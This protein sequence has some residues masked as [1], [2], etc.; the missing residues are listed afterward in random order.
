MTLIQEIK[1]KAKIVLKTADRIY[2]IKTGDII[3]CESTQNYTTFYLCDGSK[4]LI[5]ET[6]KKFDLHFSKKK[7]FRVHQSHLVN[8]DYLNYYLKGE[9]GYMVM[10]DNSKIPVSYRNKKRLLKLF[11]L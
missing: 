9:G 5:S 4:V 6:I 11:G 10:K 8:L 1:T 7:I 3:R 2:I